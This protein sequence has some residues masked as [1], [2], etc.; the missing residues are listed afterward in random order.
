MQQGLTG[1]PVQQLQSALVRIG[2]T[3]KAADGTFDHDTQTALKRFQWYTTKVNYRLKLAPK[4]KPSSGTITPYLAV[5]CPV[6]GIC[7]DVLARELLRWVTENFVTTTPLVRLN[8][9]SL[10]N[11]DTS[12]TFKVLSYPSAQ[13]EDEILVHTDFAQVISSAMNDEAK[14]AKV[15]LNINQSFRRADVPPSGA[16]VKAAKKRNTLLVM[17]QISTSL[18]AIPQ[19]PETCSR[20]VKNQMRPTHLLTQ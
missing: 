3:V 17:R 19:T 7:G 1:T 5:A 10:S 15:I 11:V 2:T 12:D 16:L 8:I 18:T 9:K 20:M 13:Q 4:A 14:K 6:S